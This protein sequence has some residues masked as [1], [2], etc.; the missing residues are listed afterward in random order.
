MNI[1]V[2]IPVYNEQNNLDSITHD[3][4]LIFKELKFNLTIC[5][6]DDGSTDKTWDN[7]LQIHQYY[8]KMIKGIRFSKH[9]GKEQAIWSGL[10]DVQ[11]DCYIVMDGDG[12][13]PPELISTF[14]DKWEKDKFDIVH[15][16]K[17][18]SHTENRLFHRLKEK[19]FYYLFR[20]V[21]GLDL[22]SASDFKLLSS[23][24]VKSLQRMGD[25][26]LFFRGMCTWI[27]F[28]QVHIPYKV[29]KRNAGKSKWSFPELLLYAMHATICFS[30]FPLY[31]LLIFGLG[32]M[33]L[34]GLLI[35]KLLW[36]YFF[37]T[38][39]P[40]GYITLLS[41]SLLSFSTILCGLGILGLYLDNILKQVME[42]PR[43]IV[44]DEI[45]PGKDLEPSFKGTNGPKTFETG[46]N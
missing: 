21:T 42:R 46:V 13:H 37:L 29:K 17:T 12:Q 15:G 1:C 24:A 7:I 41:I 44:C 25:K 32:A 36:Q 28:P 35:A 10:S 23:R 30:G 11:A 2:V 20:M 39:A 3:L 27:G 6:V 14:I 40:E 4:Q 45:N 8:P 33:I 31:V 9:F 16:V 22:R 43:F 5:F 38:Q 19:L 26:N 18:F 34:S